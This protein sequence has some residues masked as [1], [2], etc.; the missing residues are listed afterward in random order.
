MVRKVKLQKPKSGDSEFRWMR[1]GMKPGGK[2]I[3]IGNLMLMERKRIP[4]NAQ[5]VRAETKL[6][7]AVAGA[8][9][10][11]QLGS[12]NF[13]WLLCQSLEAAHLAMKE[14]AGVSLISIKHPEEQKGKR[15]KLKLKRG[16]MSLGNIF[17]MVTERPRRKRR[18]K[19]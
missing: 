13:Q 10:L 16:T 12:G 4:T 7:K 17:Q 1:A 9:P 15:A 5:I 11:I 18:A 6:Q 3:S 14:R 2:R 8:L 19:K